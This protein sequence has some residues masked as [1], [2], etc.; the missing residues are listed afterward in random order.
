MNEL[1]VFFQM[2]LD[3]IMDIHAYDHLLFMASLLLVYRIKEF[4]E[5]VIILTAFTLGHA[6]SL[7]FALIGF[8]PLED[9]MVEFLIP[10][11]I[12]LMSIYHLIFGKG[13]RVTAYSIT[14]LFGLIHGLAYAKDFMA[15]MA[16]SKNVTLPL[17][18][19]NIGVEVAQILFGLVFL[20]IV[21]SLTRWTKIERRGL[22]MFI[23]GVILTLSIQLL[24]ENRIW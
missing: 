8:T 13:K 23:F 6:L 15:M 18:G 2:G 9:E 16:G 14:V 12:V 22:S 21:E 7:A 24:I 4:R 20:L 5:V 1:G 3:H 19:F 10:L 11:T 17:L